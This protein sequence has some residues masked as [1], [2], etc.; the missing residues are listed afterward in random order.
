VCALNASALPVPVPPGEVLLSSGPL[1]DEMLPSDT[2][3][4][5]I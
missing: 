1:A 4:W 2:A 5:L 3:V